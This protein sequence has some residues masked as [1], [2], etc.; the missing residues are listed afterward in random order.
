MDVVLDLFS[1]DLLA[2]VGIESNSL[3]S[4]LPQDLK[5]DELWFLEC[6]VER[7]KTHSVSNSVWQKGSK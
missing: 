5:R 7:Y 6:H 4:L 1:F 3:L 2:T